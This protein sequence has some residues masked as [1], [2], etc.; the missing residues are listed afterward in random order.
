MSLRADTRLLA[1]AAIVLAASLALTGRLDGWR[2][3]WNAAWGRAALAR[4]EANPVDHA[5]LREALSDLGEALA[6]NPLSRKRRIEL[7]EALDL[8]VRRLGAGAVAALAPAAVAPRVEFAAALLRHAEREAAFSLIDTIDVPPRSRL[9]DSSNRI[10]RKLAYLLTRVARCEDALPLLEA[11]WGRAPVATNQRMRYA[12]CLVAVG[13]PDAG[14][15]VLEPARARRPR[16][17]RVLLIVGEA[18]L[19]KG[20]LDAAEAVS[21]RLLERRPSSYAGWYLRARVLEQRGLRE[22]STKALTRALELRPDQRWVRRWVAGR[23][24]RDRAN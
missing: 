17:R 20:D 23:D 24:E 18:H 9:L 22:E 19:A 11:Y 3:A 14:L 6:Q 21:R 4:A 5:T 8:G 7:E 1:A 2:S 10:S 13:N 12:R 15:A 16:S